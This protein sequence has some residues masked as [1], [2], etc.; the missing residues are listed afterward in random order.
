MRGVPGVR[1]SWILH[2]LDDGE[3]GYV[4]ELWDCEADALAFERAAVTNELLRPPLPGEFEF[5][6]CEIRSAW[7]AGAG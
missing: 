1:G 7:I 4:V 3:A 2:D 5:H 6:I